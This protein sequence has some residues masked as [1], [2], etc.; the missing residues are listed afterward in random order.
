MLF[1][2]SFK[3]DSLISIKNNRN[4]S[5]SFEKTSSYFIYVDGNSKFKAIVLESII[6]NKTTFL[7]SK[8][9]LNQKNYIHINEFHFY[10]V[11]MKESSEMI[12]SENS[13]NNLKNISFF[14]IQASKKMNFYI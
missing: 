12:F 6:F 1:S 2:S 11:L 3:F 13:N 9:Y 8:N 7:Y 4:L 5:I 10:D 14:N